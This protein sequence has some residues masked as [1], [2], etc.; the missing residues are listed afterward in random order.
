MLQTLA[1]SG[2]KQ[3]VEHRL[4]KATETACK[5]QEQQRQRSRP[6][7]S[8]L[9][10]KNQSFNAPMGRVRDGETKGGPRASVQLPRKAKATT[11]FLFFFFFNITACTTAQHGATTLT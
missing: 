10:A 7:A 11:S 4:M 3:P 9:F 1:R 2:K 6:T 8:L 5:H